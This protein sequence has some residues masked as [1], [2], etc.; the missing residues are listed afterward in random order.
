[1]QDP[2]WLSVDKLAAHATVP[3]RQIYGWVKSGELRAVRFGHRR[4]IRSTIE[5]LEACLEKKATENAEE[6]AARNAGAAE[7]PEAA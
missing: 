6:T 4:Q 3:E 2:K 1:M 5:W 7:P